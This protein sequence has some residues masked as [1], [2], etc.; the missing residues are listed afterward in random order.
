M[1]KVELIILGNISEIKDFLKLCG[2]IQW[3]GA[4]GTCRTVPVVIDGDGSGR[5]AGKEKKEKKG[6]KAKDG[7]A[8]PNN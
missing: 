4:H 6:K 7:D 3:C 1:E 5:H 2:K 8:E